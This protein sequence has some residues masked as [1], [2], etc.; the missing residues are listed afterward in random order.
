MS[1]SKM[2]LF[3]VAFEFTNSATRP[4]FAEIF[5]EL[6]IN[7]ISLLF[8]EN[9][10]DVSPESE[11]FEFSIDPLK[12]SPVKNDEYE[13]AFAEKTP[14]KVTLF[15]PLTEDTMQLSKFKIDLSNFIKEFISSLSLSLLI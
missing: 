2:L 12:F 14:S 15:F 6:L 5:I 10:N 1:I 7:E 8:K 11:I 9:I 3:I 13:E 4:T